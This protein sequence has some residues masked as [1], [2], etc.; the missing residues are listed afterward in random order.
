M[1]RSETQQKQRRRRDADGLRG[2]RKNLDAKIPE[3][4]RKKYEYRF[5]NNT[6]ARIHQLTVKDDWDI[7][8]DR[9][10]EILSNSA[11]AGSAA[12]VRAGTGADGR[13]VQAVLV[14]KPKDYYTDDKAAEQRRN[15]EKERAMMGKPSGEQTYSPD[16][17]G[18]MSV[19]VDNRGA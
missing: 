11:S 4:D 9:E 7:V 17:G 19:T 13:P 10:G 16:G 1:S 12:S 2:I 8:P 3:E 6:D 15:D 5:I 18:V 14:R